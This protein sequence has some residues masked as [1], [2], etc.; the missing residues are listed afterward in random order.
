MV[1]LLVMAEWVATQFIKILRAVVL[2]EELV[3]SLILPEQ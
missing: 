3:Q 2:L 1:L